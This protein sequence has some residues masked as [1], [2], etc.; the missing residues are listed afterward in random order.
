[1][2]C[3]I[4][5]LMSSLALPLAAQEVTGDQNETDQGSADAAESELILDETEAEDE[6]ESP[7]RFIPTE[8]ISQDLGVAFP[9]DI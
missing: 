3:V 8:E 1:M 5:I 6:E 9:V 4:L 2:R 7:E